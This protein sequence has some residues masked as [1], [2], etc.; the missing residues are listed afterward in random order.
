MRSHLTTVQNAAVEVVR[1][2][3]C[4][5]LGDS[6]EA[7]EEIGRFPAGTDLQKV[8]RF[9]L[10]HAVGSPGVSYSL[11]VFSHK[12]VW[13]RFATIRVEPG[14]TVDP[15]TGI[16]LEGRATECIGDESAL[17]LER[18]A[19]DRA[20]AARNSQHKRRATAAEKYEKTGS[21]H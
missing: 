16:I 9:T 7:G 4:A 12:G 8:R 21:D 1:V 18:E 17:K 6:I 19:F 15:D 3:A 13:E 14:T 10:A 20:R 11:D 5:E 2:V